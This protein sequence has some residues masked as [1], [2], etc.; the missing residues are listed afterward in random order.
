MLWAQRNDTILLTISVNDLHNEKYT[1]NDK[2]LKF[3][4]EGTETL[5]KYE[6]ELEFFKE[7]T[8]QVK[9]NIVWVTI[10]LL[11]YDWHTHS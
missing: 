10:C 2:T 1:V 9:D 3:Y 11:F 4:G 7:I 8:P 6:F 5:Q